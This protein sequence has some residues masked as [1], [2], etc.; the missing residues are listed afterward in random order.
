LSSLAAE[1]YCPKTMLQAPFTAAIAAHTG[2]GV[3]GLAFY[4]ESANRSAA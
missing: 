1:R 3:F 4:R 2:P